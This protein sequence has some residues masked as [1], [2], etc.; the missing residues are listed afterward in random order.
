M[1]TVLGLIVLVLVVLWAGQRWLIYFPE[2][3]VPLLQVV[4]LPTGEPI[5]FSTEDD[6]RLEGWFVHP[7]GRPTGQTV[8]VFNGNGGNRAHRAPLAAALVRAGHAVLLFDYRGYGGNPGLPSER[9]L[10]RDA[11]AAL[12]AVLSRQDVDGQ[13]IVYFGESIG[14]GVAVR[15]ASERPPHA[16]ILRSPFTSLTDVGRHH[17][18][19]LPVRWLLRDRFASLDYIAALRA[20]LLVIGGTG[21]QI[22]PFE[23]T[24][25]LYEAAPDPKW[26]VTIE[27]ADH[28]DDVLLSGRPVVAAILKFL[29]GV[30]Q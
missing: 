6:L 14:T 27:G 7:A 28:N 24:E 17:Y 2:R 8:I 20:P 23:L 5:A 18:P 9:G 4:G 1:Q 12:D 15:L 22:V 26:L 30:R 3:H 11:R 10:H 19:F 13:R 29:D 21:D 25:D 16:L